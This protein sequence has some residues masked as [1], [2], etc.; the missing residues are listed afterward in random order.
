MAGYNYDKSGRNP[1]DVK[2]RTKTHSRASSVMAGTRAAAEKARAKAGK[3]GMAGMAK[4]AKKAAPAS[5]KRGKAGKPTPKYNVGVSR[6]GVSFNEA[7]RH[8]KNR[9]QKTFTWN[10]KKY[11]TEAA[12]TTTTTTPKAAT[13]TVGRGRNKGTTPAEKKTY[14]QKLRE[15]QEQ[16]G[17]AAKRRA[18]AFMANRDKNRLT[19]AQ[20]KKRRE[21]ARN[22][23]PLRQRR[24]GY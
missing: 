10:G 22:R 14:A 13:K 6:G 24:M 9:G 4:P 8:F 19:P 15:K 16:R 1:G 12:T 7:F 3:A 5:A 20:S 23:R 2:R 11:T 18:E 17:E 21:E